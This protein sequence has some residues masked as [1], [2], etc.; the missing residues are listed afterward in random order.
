MISL[1]LTIIIELIQILDEKANGIQDPFSVE[2]ICFKG[3]QEYTSEPQLKESNI[4]VPRKPFDRLQAFN[5][6]LIFNTVPFFFSC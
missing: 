6:P 2:F 4:I 5:F 3:N 1:R